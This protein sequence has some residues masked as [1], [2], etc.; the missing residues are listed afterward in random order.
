MIHKTILTGLLLSFFSFAFAATEFYEVEQQ[1]PEF[2]IVNFRFPEPVL[3]SGK[4][5][6]RLVSISVPGLDY[7][8]EAGRPLLPVFST[9]LVAPQGKVAWEIL[10]SE[11]K[12]YPGVSP[13][14]YVSDSQDS[15]HYSVDAAPMVYPAQ[16]VNINESGIFRD[17][18]IMGLQIFPAQVTTSGIQYF[19]SLKIKIRFSANNNQPPQNLAVEERN[20]FDK[21]A[22]NG[23]QVSAIAPIIPAQSQVSSMPLHA[24]NVDNQAKIYVDQKGIYRVTGQ[25]LEDAG[26]DLG[27]INP[28]SLRLT[29]KGNDVAI[30]VS[31]DQDQEFDP[32]DYLEF[33][34]ERNE[35]TFLA[36]YP[37]V[38]ADPFS[39]EN[40]YWL[41]WGG[42]NGLRM[43]EESGA[44]IQS[45][46][47]QYNLAR[48][49]PFTV[50]YEK[51]NVFERLGYGNTHNLTYTRDSWFFDSGIQAIGKKSY[52]LDLSYPDSNSYNPVQV[53]MKFTGKSQTSHTMMVWLNQR[54]VGQTAN[55]WYAQQP[56]TLSTGANSSIRTIDLANGRNDLEIQMPSIAAQNQTDYVL[57]NW[58][59]ITY[60]RQYRADDNSLE[61]TRPALASVYYPNNPLYQFELTGFTR[62][63]IEIYKKGISK[64]VNYKLQVEGT[65]N[66]PRYRII[67]QD[68]IYSPDVD[69]L[70]VASN[71]RL[72]PLRIE[73]DAPYDEQNPSLTL[74]DPANSADYLIITHDKFYDLA[75]ELAD[76][77]R[78]QG[79][80]VVMVKVQDIYDEFNDGI[81]S[82]LA[83]K[84]FLKY[85][86]YN[87]DHSHRLKYVLLLGDANENYKSRNPLSLDYVPTFFFQSEKFG[88]IASDLPYALVSGDDYLPDL[89]IGR[90]PVSSNSGVVN[91]IA[92]IK[93][94]VQHPVIGTWRN[95]T[96]FIS[97]NDKST[98]EISGD[99]EVPSHKPAFRTQNQRIIDMLLPRN[100]TSFKLNTIKDD[101]L[102][103]DPNYGGPTD[104]IEYFDDGVKFMTFL[105]HG[106]GAIWADV[107]LFNL[108]DVNRL[109]NQGMY[110]F[111]ASMTCF[112]GAFE[113]P[114]N[115]GLA[116]KMVLA[117]DKGAIGMMGS[118]GLGWVSND[119][120]I[121]WNV[122]KHLFASGL[123][124]GEAV[125][126]GKIDY[127]LTSQY[128][129]NDT[130][131]SG[132]QWGHSILKY[133]M[134]HQYNLIG[135]PYI[136][137][138]NPEQDLTV[139]ADNDLPGRGDTIQVSVNSNISSGEGYLELSNKDNEVVVREP[140]FSSG[141]QLTHSIA[142]PAT[143]P[144]GPGYLRAYLSDN[145]TDASGV[146]QVAVNYAILD[147]VRIIPA[148]P[149][150]ED[151][152]SIQLSVRDVLDVS[153]VN[154]VA[155]LPNSAS[156][157]DTIHLRTANIAPNT[158]RTVGKIPPALAPEIVYYFIY[159]INSDGQVRK[160]NGNYEVVET[161]PDPL[162]YSGKTRL[163][164][165]EK[166]KLGVSIGNSGDIP[167]QDV[168]IRA[169]NG[170]DNYIS[171]TPFASQT[172]SIDG[173]DSV[174]IKMDFPFALNIPTYRIYTVVNRQGQS[175]DFN[176]KN[177]I[178]SVSLAVNMVNL[179]PELG[180]TYT[181]A[182][183]DT[184]SVGN[185][186]QFRMAPGVI[187]EP[188][189]AMLKIEKFPGNR[190]QTGLQSIPLK[191]NAAPEIFR[192]K[193]FNNDAQVNTP[194]FL[195]LL[196]NKAAIDSGSNRLA[197]AKL[198]RW[199]EQT[200]V[201]QNEPAV[202]DTALGAL[203]ATPE[204]DGIYAPFFSSD[205][206]PPNIE[207]TINGRHVRAKTL[208]A[209]NP[210]LHVLIEDESGLN[211]S[212]EQI[213]IL[214]DGIKVPDEQVLIPDSVQQSK[215]LGMTV[216]PEL[217]LGNHDLKVEVKDVNGNKTTTDYNLQVDDAFDLH[218]FGNY[219]NPFT[220]QTIFSYY[221]SSPSGEIID[222]FEIR[223]YTVSGRLIR[224]IKN[225]ENTSAPG[226]NDS[227][228][229]GYG[230]LIWK[231]IDDD[232][233]EVANGV[234]F[235]L[236]RAKFEGKEKEEILK[237]AK[238]K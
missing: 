27:S 98:Y 237:V 217:D 106:G 220:D 189:A 9:S 110:P 180:S 23:S 116:Q 16:V 210:V 144:D 177:N 50:H 169:Y 12:N 80:N 90:L 187:A 233:N 234:Y 224:R 204:K 134:I 212:R 100:Y 135:D 236:I 118:S 157:S 119:Y 145:S 162:V 84:S 115:P 186:G 230:E 219:P 114:G 40:V 130:I 104:L 125:T 207:L 208:V 61:F 225:D 105:G 70:A 143:F 195:K 139:S 78:Q 123:S 151:S 192:I 132:S 20:L 206:K 203:I 226:N 209:P 92:K 182:G 202:V 47:T 152:V 21:F 54:L 52:S 153:E 163:V 196:L 146:K 25:D 148:V 129:M 107:S 64:I 10:S 149:N 66:H 173:K 33:W 231:G 124:V 88:A 222:D 74:K 221:I 159:V 55:E 19:A 185:A 235:A 17:Y 127:F 85:A 183:N 68:N 175:P 194:Y 158:Y 65:A 102:Q 112:T 48:F 131:V 191:G 34:G 24:N 126:L 164:G 42:A 181:G 166:V 91:V 67:F 31:G 72:K 60:D 197:D 179:T 214:I 215:I 155:I 8:Y 53:T 71:A 232:G 14:V 205:S 95:Q 73:K 133:D 161:R 56:F 99:P 167:A 18:R 6:P 223:I 38:Y 28:Q 29:N 51:D 79:L 150:A 147:S 63:D 101:S 46:S 44:I 22:L 45:N 103:F 170:H 36:Q 172:V 75:Q 108:D 229:I 109:N 77:R 199:N 213:G 174:T 117:R 171:D 69:Y 3:T 49:Y 227:R 113:N 76:F 128:V 82:P 178:D 97:G 200:Q 160:L 193:F 93:E 58:A 87:W 176:S 13:V 122:A 41:S 138:Q 96:L 137:L 218:V 190:T 86:F 154:L 168:V 111:I 7:N 228:R 57:F 121:L 142:I 5:N 11:K 141:G 59:D 43:I 165:E 1:T 37:D 81:K 4:L 120:A 89:F 26:I 211:I 156:Q 198:Y 32:E 39:D 30:F 15:A 201:W 184:I 140:I 136:F 94:Y 35:K 188:S 216:Y 62:P 83:I 238:L 2:I